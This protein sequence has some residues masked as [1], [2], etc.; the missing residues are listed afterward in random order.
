MNTSLAVDLTQNQEILKLRTPTRLIYGVC[1]P[2][3]VESN[4][5]AAPRGLK[6]GNF[7][8]DHFHTK[9]CASPPPKRIAL[10]DKEKDLY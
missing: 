3:L 10:V 8:N 5:V 4:L 9:S 1:W 7:L 2:G 6:F